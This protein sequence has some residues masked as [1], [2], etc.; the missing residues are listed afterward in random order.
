M[1]RHVLFGGCPGSR[2]ALYYF[3]LLNRLCEVADR[4]GTFKGCGNS[5]RFFVGKAAAV[6]I[7]AAVAVPNRKHGTA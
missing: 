3:V 2:V 5:V 7:A 6:A 4:L 1:R